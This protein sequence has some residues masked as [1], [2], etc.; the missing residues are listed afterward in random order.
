MILFSKELNPDVIKAVKK[1]KNLK[2]QEDAIKAELETLKAEIVT[3]MGGDTQAACKVNGV[4]FSITYKEITS[5]R[6]DSKA[7]KEKY[8]AIYAECSTTSTAPR[9]TLK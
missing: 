3:A 1:F 8:P 4:S 6:L 9:F 5:T 2:A 7:V